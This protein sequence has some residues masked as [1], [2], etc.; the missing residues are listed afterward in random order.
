MKDLVNEIVRWENGEMNE[1]QQVAFFQKM[2]DS[3]LCWKLQG[4]YGRTA[5]ELIDQGLCKAKEA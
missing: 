5:Q 1:E 4:Q 3:G 2:I